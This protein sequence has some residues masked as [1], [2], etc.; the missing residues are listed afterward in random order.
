MERIEI[1][2]PLGLIKTPSLEDSR[3]PLNIQLMSIGAS[4]LVTIQLTETVLPVSYASSPNSNGNTIGTTS[5]I[6][7]NR[8]EETKT[9][10][11]IID[12]GNSADLTHNL[13]LCRVLGAASTVACVAGVVAGVS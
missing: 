2:L 5:E 8:K 1:L 12:E 6:T 9:G 10:A 7:Q 3:R 13:Q 11:G 4:P